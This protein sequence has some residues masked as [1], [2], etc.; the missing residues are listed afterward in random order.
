M[1]NKVKPVTNK[2]NFRKNKTLSKYE[3]RVM[4]F[5]LFAI[6]FLLFAL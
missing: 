1:K 2:K 5:P 3:E 6:L 4:I